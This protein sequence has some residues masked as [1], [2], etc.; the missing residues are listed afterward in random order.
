MS[1][2]RA[3]WARGWMGVALT[4]GEER[5][6]AAAYARVGWCDAGFDVDTSATTSNVCRAALFINHVRGVVYSG[7]SDTSRAGGSFT[8][9]TAW[10]ARY[11]TFL[12]GRAAVFRWF[13]LY[14]PP[15]GLRTS[16]VSTAPAGPC[17]PGTIL[18]KRGKTHTRLDSRLSP[19]SRSAVGD[20]SR[21]IIS[22]VSV[23]QQ[24][25]PYGVHYEPQT[26]H[27]RSACSL[28][29]AQPHRRT[30]SIGTFNF[31][32]PGHRQAHSVV[33]AV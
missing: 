8:V 11:D 10:R 28:R 25:V 20:D 22:S 1:V 31:L 16:T 2:W 26:V 17:P 32:T 18:D 5:G 12:L 6:R 14:L 27:A 21:Y 4:H 19:V 33:H 23:E 3:G 13:T 15:Y 7:R 30:Y 24:R 29:A 9:S